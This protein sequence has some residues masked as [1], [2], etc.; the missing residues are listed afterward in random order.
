MYVSSLSLYSEFYL[1]NPF[2][3]QSVFLGTI[4]A[5]RDGEIIKK[6]FAKY[7]QICQVFSQALSISYIIHPFSQEALYLLTFLTLSWVLG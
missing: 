6:I 1:F 3:F 4:F 5:T 7:F 2:G